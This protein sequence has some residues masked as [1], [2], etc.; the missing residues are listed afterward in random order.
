MELP[1]FTTLIAALHDGVLRLSLNR[2]Q[3]GNA[4]SSAMVGE[5]TGALAQAEASGK[6]R[7]VVL[8]GEGGNFSA[9]ADLKEMSAI[10]AQPAEHGRDPANA[11]SQAFGNMCAKFAAT[12][13]AT[14][15][16]VDGGAMGGG[17][18]LACAVDICIATP[19]ARFG[20]PE[21]RRGL[22]PAQIAPYLLERLG[23]SRAKLL[24][25]LGGSIRAD[26]AL[27]L[28]LVHEVTEEA[29]AAVASAV[30]SILACAP[31]AV[32]ATKKLLRL[33]RFETPADFIGHAAD[34]FARA[35]RGAE[36]REGATA[37]LQKRPPAW[38]TKTQS[39]GEGA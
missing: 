8:S 16:L 18:G 1:A 37:F 7:V 39:G 38:A 22:I 26:E 34:V 9:G 28:G 32:A 23:Y 20:L 11:Y 17:F 5:L 35:V 25:V 33:I 19:N 13:L 27:R 6:V 24:A 30:A 29:E 10:M 15:A 4:M 14:I 2:P 36:G 12:P 31:E 21:T 3:I